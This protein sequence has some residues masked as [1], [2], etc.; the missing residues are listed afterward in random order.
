MVDINLGDVIINDKPYR[1]LPGTKRKQDIVDFS[2]RASTPGG[3]IIHSELGLYQPLLQTS[4][5]HGMGFS[6]YEDAQGYMRTD[7][8]IDTRHAGIAMLFTAAVVSE[9][10]ANSKEGFTVFDGKLWSWGAAGLRSFNGTSWSDEYSVA[11]VNFALALGTYLFYCPN[12]ARIRKVDLSGVHTDAGA[13]ANSSDYSSLVAHN[14]YVYALKD[15]T[16]IVYYGSADD[17]SDLFGVPADDTNEIYIG[18]G[19]VPVIGH[20]QAFSRLFWRREDG[21]W[22]LGEDRIARRVLNYG[23]ERSSTNFRSA[24]EHNGF[25]VYAVRDQLFQWNGLRQTPITPPRLTDTF[26]YKTVGRFD[27]FV[28]VGDYFYAT[29]RTNE[30]TY[31]ESLWCFDGV[32][33]HKLLDLITDGDGE[34]SAM[35]YD[36]VNERLWV[37]IA[38]A[39]S[40]STQYIQFQS[41]SE[42]PY[43][44][45][46][47]TGTHS[48]ISSRLDMG[49]RRVIKSTPSMWV[50][51]SNLTSTRYL[52]IYYSLDGGAWTL[53]KTVT[54]DGVTEL[55]EPGGEE[56]REY[57]YLLVRVDFA[58]ADATQSPILESFTVRFLMRPDEGYGYSYDII[59]GGAAYEGQD[60]MRT[61]GEMDEELEAA[62]ASKAPVEFTDHLGRVRHG[63]ISA[64]T[65]RDIEENLVT[66]DNLKNVE[67]VGHVNL[68]V[69]KNG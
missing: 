57:N 49:F 14:G 31:T 30:T 67:S 42:F 65:T 66:Y 64:Y 47:T 69:T 54:Q 10:N 51:A 26:P 17:L 29:A 7:G 37:H 35:G 18:P 41:Q 44:N 32:G 46:P 52:S 23:N 15:G 39:A 21:L 3:S 1:V 4:W 63:Y 27:N 6:W 50:E 40:H 43:G 53:W 34:V 13:G 33:W 16:N 48:L 5:Q 28:V 38:K 59:L 2:P 61:A 25:L 62:R 22:E 19:S 45:F 58:T 68:V 36:T 9:T 55:D 56:T 12:G 20:V 24:A 60:Y 11:A 8:N